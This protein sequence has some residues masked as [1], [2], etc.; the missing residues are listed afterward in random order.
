MPARR[1]APKGMTLLETMIAVTILATAMIGMAQFMANFAHATKTSAVEAG[2]LDLATQRIDAVMHSPTYVA[3]DSMAATE[4]TVADSTQY[5]RQTLVQH[6]GGGPS[7]T[8]DYRI[9]TV[10]VTPPGGIAV[11]RKTTVIAAF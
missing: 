8:Q 11:T 10:I 4:S 2:A 5:Q 6:V 7:D 9:V 1:R 3:I